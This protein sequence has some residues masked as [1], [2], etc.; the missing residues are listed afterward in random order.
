MARAA[1][2][3]VVLA[4][5]VASIAGAWAK[6][7]RVDRVA[8]GD[9]IAVTGRSRVRLVQIDTPELGGE[10]YGRR[11][12]ADLR[13]LIP[14][15]TAVRLQAD[16]R[17]DQVDRY[18]RLLRYV[19]RGGMNVNL[20]LVARGDATVWLY[21]GARGRYAATLLWAARRARSKRRGLWGACT[22]V[23]NPL[24]PATTSRRGGVPPRNTRCDPSYQGVCIPSPPPDL[25]CADVRYRNFRV[26]PPDPQHFDADGDGRGCES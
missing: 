2:A 19:F 3:A 22:A 8:D 24:G 7:T 23:W 10:C 15:G 26:R 25:D 14:P 17:L 9:T 1:M 13:R 12:A 6:S 21:D 5:A 18:G 4:L 16:P 20:A 11:A